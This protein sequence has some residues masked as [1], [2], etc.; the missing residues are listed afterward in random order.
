MLVDA[1]CDPI[2]LVNVVA[3]VN[4]RIQQLASLEELKCHDVEMKKHYIDHFP[5]DIPHCNNLPDDMLFRVQPK[6]TNKLI[7]LCSYDCPKKYRDSW[8]MLLQQHITAG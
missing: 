6:D 1:R 5:A 4:T 2:S 8:H 7:Q 3:A